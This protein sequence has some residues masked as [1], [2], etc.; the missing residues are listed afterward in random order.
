M[1]SFVLTLTFMFVATVVGAQSITG[2]TI[3]Y[4]DPGAPAARQT[5]TFTAGVTVCNQVAPVV[6]ATNPTRIFWDDLANAGKVCVFTATASNSLVSF[7]IGSYELTLS[8]TNAAGSSPES[9][10]RVPFVRLS[11]PA[12]PTGVK[13]AP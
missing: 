3:K 11:A 5:E 9:A 6:G 8:A 2:Y 1:K 4:Y 13:V 12:A 7:P 10:P